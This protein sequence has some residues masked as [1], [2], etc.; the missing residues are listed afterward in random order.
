M[1]VKGKMILLKGLQEW[2]EKGMR[3]NSGGDK[4]K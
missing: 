2:V 4:F 3:E 1:Y